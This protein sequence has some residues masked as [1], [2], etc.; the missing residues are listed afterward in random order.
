M[1]LGVLQPTERAGSNPLLAAQTRK[2]AGTLATVHV[3]QPA[4]ALWAGFDPR[5]SSTLWLRAP[6]CRDSFYS[7]LYQESRSAARRISVGVVV[8]VVVLR[9]IL[10]FRLERSAIE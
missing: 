3:L 6:C 9:A 8:V 5:N 4:S 10:H 1:S 7:C 2:A